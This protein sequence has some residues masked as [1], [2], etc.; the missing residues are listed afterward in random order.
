MTDNKENPDQ[1]QQSSFANLNAMVLAIEWEISDESMNSLISEI[2]RLKKIYKDNKIIY[3]FLQLHGSVSKYIR[4]KKVNSHPD[5]INLLHSIYRGLEKVVTSPQITRAEAKMILSAE[6][7]KFKELKQRVIQAKSDVQGRT[8][9]KPDNGET[10]ADTIKEVITVE[11]PLSHDALGFMLE[12]I[13]KTMRAE[14]AV[15]RKE[16]KSWQPEK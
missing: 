1:V 3:S 15:L 6:V 13:K 5:S 9:K 12:E 10:P 2:N 4:S 14:F 11:T 8:D 16:L 7:K